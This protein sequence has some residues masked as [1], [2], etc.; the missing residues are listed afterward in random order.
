MPVFPILAP[1]ARAGFYAVDDVAAAGDG[2]EGPDAPVTPAPEPP[3][4]PDLPELPD[5][6][7]PGEEDPESRHAGDLLPLYCPIAGS[8]AWIMRP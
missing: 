8:S 3:G 1:A 6:E 4:F 2:T 7:T 5:D